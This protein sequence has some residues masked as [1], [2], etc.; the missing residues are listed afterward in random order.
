MQM[1]LLE[2]GNAT[3]GVWLGK[4]ILNQVDEIRHELFGNVSTLLQI[5]IPRGQNAHLD[6]APGAQMIDTC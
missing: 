5:V 2:Q 4:N 1:K 3:M 6:A